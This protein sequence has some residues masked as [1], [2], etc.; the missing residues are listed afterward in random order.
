MRLKKG[1]GEK[2]GTRSCSFLANWPV[3]AV[4]LLFYAISLSLNDWHWR[5]N[6]YN[7]KGTTKQHKSVTEGMV[8]LRA[9]SVRGGVTVTPN[10]LVRTADGDET[11]WREEGL[12]VR[13]ELW[14]F[15]WLSLDTE[16]K[17]STPLPVTS[18][19]N[20]EA[21]EGLWSWALALTSQGHSEAL[22][23]YTDKHCLWTLSGQM[24]LCSDTEIKLNY[25]WLSHR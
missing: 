16:T 20:S 4:W 2:G 3:T 15:V 18:E 9:D 21:G 23:E 5:H 6:A 7:S 13:K 8:Q 11:W 14:W 19:D 22:V 10:R 17:Q 25:H 12:D 1:K 24:L